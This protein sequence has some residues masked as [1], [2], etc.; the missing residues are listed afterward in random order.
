MA[1]LP[2]LVSLEAHLLGDDYILSDVVSLTPLP[3][4]E[5]QDLHRDGG[6]IDHIIATNCVIALVDFDSSNGPTRFVPGSH[7]RSHTQNGAP[8]IG[9]IQEG[10]SSFDERIF[11]G[12]AGSA[13]LY[14]NR[15]VHGRGPNASPRPRYTMS[16][17]CCRSWVKPFMDH[18]VRGAL[19]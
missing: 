13:L 7:Q 5:A 6:N 1:Q 9:R 17:F 3:G 18:T 15:L 14:D 12:R 4:N 8:G 19:S 2:R 10:E 16:L 11:E